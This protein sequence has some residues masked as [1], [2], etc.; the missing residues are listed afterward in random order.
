MEFACEMMELSAQLMILPADALKQ[1]SSFITTLSGEQQANRTL[2]CA[3][4]C[5]NILQQ[6]DR[7]VVMKFMAELKTK[8]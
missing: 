4:R 1:S 6:T 5:M 7:E 8:V 3:L 2:A